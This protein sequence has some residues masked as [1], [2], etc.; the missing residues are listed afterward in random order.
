[1]RCVVWMRLQTAVLRSREPLQVVLRST[2]RLGAQ[3]L[4]WPCMRLILGS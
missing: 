1:M 3:V 2:A 4:W